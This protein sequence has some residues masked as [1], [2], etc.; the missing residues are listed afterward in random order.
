MDYKKIHDDLI[1]YCK[2]TSAK[3]RLIKRNK[4]DPRLNDEYIYTEK[5]HIIPK[6]V[7]GNDSFSNLVVLL[8][9]EHYMIHL[10]RY[11]WEKH[12]YDFL[13]CRFMINGYVGKTS[14]VDCIP[15]KVTSKMIA[16][17]KQKIY[18]FRKH[19]GWQSPEG[20]KSISK[21]RTGTFPVKCAK[22][23]D[24]IGSFDRNHP[25]ILSGE[26][27][28]HSKG[29]TTGKDMDG[30][31]VVLP[32]GYFK[33]N[34]DC[35]LYTCSYAGL[36][37]GT[38]NTNYKGI[39]DKDKEFL[40]NLLPLCV[41]RD[42]KNVLSKN[43]VKVF[44]EKYFLLNGFKP[45]SHVWVANHLGKIKDIVSQYNEKFNSDLIYNQYY[46]PKGLGTKPRRNNAKN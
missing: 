44:N 27:V 38:E 13:A 4:L 17:F 18:L 3:E 19:T 40:I 43:I 41:D 10:L 22:T 28:H 8:P 33:D 5:H 1:D 35:E 11:K 20:I 31:S 32:A 30:N 39:S 42:T 29:N 7:G 9:E 21:A 23:G 14:L 37:V 25:K 15:D 16:S 45:I 24:I 2:K 12:R 6:H 36:G 34:P 46:R 26:W